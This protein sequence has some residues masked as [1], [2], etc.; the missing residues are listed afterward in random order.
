MPE[1]PLD[2]QGLIV[3]INVVPPNP[4]F[5]SYRELDFTVFGQPRA[6]CRVQR[7]RLP[8]FLLPDDYD[9]APLDIQ[10][11]CLLYRGVYYYSNSVDYPYIGLRAGT[12]YPIPACFKRPNH[13]F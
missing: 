9:N 12:E 10:Q 2:P 11:K 8:A 13:G 6:F 5:Q 4:F 7:P 3:G 1:L